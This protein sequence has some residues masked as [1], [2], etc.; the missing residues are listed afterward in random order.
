MRAVRYHE[1]GG[2]AVLQVDEIDRP[3]PKEHEILVE[4]RAASINPVDAK[5]RQ[6]G[7][8][9]LPKTTG[10]DFAGVVAA[11][12]DAVDRY[13]IGD[14]VFG[15]GLHADRF[16]QGSF[17]EY[18]TVPRDIL[19]PLP[20]VVSFEQGAGVALV[21]VTAWRALIDYA[22]LRPG[23]ACLIHGGSG[24]VGHAAVQLAALTNAFVVTTAGSKAARATVQDLGADV[25]FDYARD[26]LLEAV[27]DINDTGIDVILDHRVGDYLHFDVSV[28][29]FGGR[30]VGYGGYE[31]KITNASTARAKELTMYWTSMSNLVNREGELPTIRS[32]LHKL[33]RLMAE[34]HLTA[35]VAEVFD[36]EEATEMHEAVINESF[37]GKL[38]VKP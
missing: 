36:L 7:A 11:T 5:R 18:V 4:I 37:V 21:G 20:D 32:V 38:V 22:C 27:R 26:D 12:G 28:A 23:E 14:R 10:S 15:T 8:G 9:Q 33:A 2:A 31:C 34:D 35:N 24:G 13:Q 16:Q 25:G 30:I 3:V 19:A 1:S 29:A 17:A 6:Q